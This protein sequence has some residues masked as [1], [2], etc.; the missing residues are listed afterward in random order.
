VVPVRHDGATIAEISVTGADARATDLALLHHT[1]AVSAG[2][3]RNL[4]LLAELAALQATIDQQNQEV[5]ASHRRLVAAAEAEQERLA[6]LVGQRLGPD[7]AALREALP[8]LREAL[9]GLREALP[10]LRERVGRRPDLVTADCDRLAVRAG[11]VVDELRGLSRGVLPPVLLD[12]GLAAALRALLR[13][14]DREVTLRVAPPVDTARFPAPLETTAYL[15]CRAAVEAA[16]PDGAPGTDLRLWLAGGALA[17]SVS[18]AAPRPASPDLAALRDR[19][20]TLGGEL[21]V[22]PAGEWSTLIGTLPLPAG[23]AAGTRSRSSM[24]AVS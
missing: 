11:R 14:L 20:A 21:V 18:H 12:H 17:F 15:C 7:L 9:P 6:R 3:L 5:A 24:P 22:A 19:V 2:A 23:P 16:G 13:R 4:R 8:G 1:A 10:G